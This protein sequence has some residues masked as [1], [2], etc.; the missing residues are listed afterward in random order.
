M[1]GLFTSRT[2]EVRFSDTDAMGVVWHGNYLRYFEDA[3]EF[4]GKEFSLEYLDIH[5]M[6]FFVPITETSIKHLDTINYGDQIQVRV[7]FIF[8]KAAKIEFHYELFNQTTNR[9]SAKGTSTQVFVNSENREMILS[10]PQFF[11][12]WESKQDWTDV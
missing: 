9:V 6:G 3:R 8:N 11:K 2:I 1:R 12:D 4:F 5:N 7:K 10:K